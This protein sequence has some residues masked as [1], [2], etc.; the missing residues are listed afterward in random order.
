MKYT[1]ECH[2]S[3]GICTGNPETSCHQRDEC[4]LDIISRTCFV[5]WAW[6][7]ESQQE[8]STHRAWP[9]RAQP[10]RLL[11][12]TLPPACCPVPEPPSP[13]QPPPG[14]PAVPVWT[15]CCVTSLSPKAHLTASLTCFEH[16]LSDCQKLMISLFIRHLDVK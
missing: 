16:V 8:R 5:M 10:C 6:D 1:S 9:C 15:S 14:K 12:H 11:P 2:Q 4:P 7:L 13:S 3:A